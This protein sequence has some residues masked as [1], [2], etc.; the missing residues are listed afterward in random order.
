MFELKHDGFRAVAYVDRDGTRLVSR[1]GNVYRSFPH[2]CNSIGNELKCE[3]GLDGEILC[4]DA[5]G[6]PQF[7]EL[8]RRRG[9]PVLYVFDL[10]WL[11]GE[12][13][14]ELHL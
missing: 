4:L 5:E 3:A 13:L 1:R 12:D 11:D 8:L 6:R 9:E 2:L 10:L 7:Y 14:R